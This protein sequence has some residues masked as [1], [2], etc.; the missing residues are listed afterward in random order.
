ML[1]RPALPARRPPPTIGIGWPE[2]ERPM[3]RL[4]K[5][6]VSTVVEVKVPPVPILKKPAF[7]RKKSRF[8]GKKR[9]KRVRLTCCSSTSTWAK[10]VL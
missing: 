4:K 2:S 9:L 3:R 10:S 7:S 8:S 6:S 1:W 5:R